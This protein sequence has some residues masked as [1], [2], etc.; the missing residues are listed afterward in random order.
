VDP[1]EVFSKLREVQSVR[2]RKQLQAQVLSQLLA[3]K[4]GRKLTAPQPVQDS[5]PPVRETRI[6]ELPINGPLLEAVE[7]YSDTVEGSHCVLM[8]TLNGN[9]VS[10]G[11]E[12]AIY[13][14]IGENTQS[15]E[16]QIRRRLAEGTPVLLGKYLVVQR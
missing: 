12:D 3:V 10:C 8:N 14:L 16:P 6:P 9:I 11:I 5:P 7:A 2:R 15:S 1:N 4:P 13:R